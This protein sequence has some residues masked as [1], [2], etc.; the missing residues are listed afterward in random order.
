MCI[1]TSLEETGFADTLVFRYTIRI[2]FMNLLIPDNGAF[3]VLLPD[4]RLHSLRDGHLIIE[5]YQFLIIRKQISNGIFLIELADI[6]LHAVDGFLL[7]FE[8]SLFL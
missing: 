1:P 6:C 8:P 3:D 7:F 4:H 5:D 2:K